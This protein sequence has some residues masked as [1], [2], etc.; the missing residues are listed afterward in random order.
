MTGKGKKLFSALLLIAVLCLVCTCAFAAYNWVNDGGCG[1]DH[2]NPSGAAVGCD[3]HAYEYKQVDAMSHKKTQWH[4]PVKEGANIYPSFFTER[5]EWS[6]SGS[7]DTTTFTCKFCGYS[8]TTDNT[9]ISRVVNVVPTCVSTGSA[10]WSWVRHA[11][12]GTNSNYGMLET[13]PVD[14]NNHVG[15]TYNVDT[16]KPSCT[17]AHEWNICCSSCNAVIGQDHEHMVRSHGYG[18]N[19]EWRV[20]KPATCGASGVESRICTIKWDGVECGA[21]IETRSIPATGKHTYKLGDYDK[22]KANFTCTTCRGTWQTG[23]RNSKV[24]TDEPATCIGT[25]FTEYTFDIYD[26]DGKYVQE[27]AFVTRYAV[28]PKKHVGGTYNVQTVAPTC[29]TAEEWDVYCSSC[30]TVIRHDFERFARSHGSK[31][32][33]RT[34]KPASCTADGQKELVCTA[35][36]G[37]KECG[38][39]MQTE[40]IPATGHKWDFVSCSKNNSTWKCLTCGQQTTVKNKNINKKETPATCTKGGSIVYYADIIDP[41]G[42][43]YRSQ[44]GMPSQSIPAPGHSFG[45]WVTETEATC[46]Q[47]GKEIRTCGICGE[48]EERVISRKQHDFGESEV[49]KK[50]SCTEIGLEKQTCKICGFELETAGKYAPGHKYGQE[51]ERVDPTADAAGYVIYRCTNVWYGVQCDATCRVDLAKLDPQKTGE[52]TADPAGTPTAKPTATPTAKPTAAPTAKPT[53]TPTAKP[54]AAPT[55]KPTAT[56]TAKPTTAPTAEPEGSGGTPT[57]D[58]EGSGGTPTADPEGSGETP[59]T[60]PEGS[61]ET[62][63]TDP[64]GSGGTPTADPEGSGETP[65]ADPEG[66]GGTPTAKPDETDTGKHDEEPEGGTAD[67][68]TC[69]HEHTTVF[70]GIDPTC[71]ADGCTDT[72]VCDDCGKVISGGEII[73]AKGHTPKDVDRV[74]PTETKDGHEAGQVCEDCGK[75]LE[76]CEV[77]PKTGSDSGDSETPGGSEGTEDCPH[78]KLRYQAGVEPTCTE[79]GRSSGVVCEDCGKLIAGGETIP[80]LGHDW[81]HVD[82]EDPTATESGHE[83]GTRCERCGETEGCEEIPALGSGADPETCKHE[84]TH[85]IPGQEPTCDKPGWEDI[86]VCEDCGKTLSGCGEIPALGHDPVEVGRVEPTETEPGHEEGHV[87][88]R[89]GEILDG[90]K[91]IP[92]T[93]KGNTDLLTK[94]ADPDDDVEVRKIEGLPGHVIVITGGDEQSAAVFELVE[95]H[96]GDKCPWC[97]DE[98]SEW[99]DLGDGRHIRVCMDPECLYYE[100]AEHPCFIICVDG[101]DYSICPICGAFSGDGS[102]SRLS[103]VNS[104]DS[105]ALYAFKDIAPWGESAV[106]IKNFSDDKVT[107]AG[108]FTVVR[109]KDGD[110]ALFGGAVDLLVPVDVNASQLVRMTIEGEFTDV[111]AAFLNGHVLFGTDDNGLYLL[112][113]K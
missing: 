17:K 52:P 12:D 58:P 13:L 103:G 22:N 112:L 40:K 26:P 56:P 28:D 36:W 61:G 34:V 23:N 76:G 29:T 65:T 74:E 92:A 59:T 70:P 68:E 83:A 89:C 43:V 82:R 38:Y 63:T 106:I 45:D 101:V 79:P 100:V 44:Y 85:M 53:A 97:G 90:C 105:R 6:I 48:K 41:D 24:K 81:K 67:P 16:V 20:T 11:P 9:D 64:E 96:D 72:V 30:N 111:T 50:K 113:S 94:D 62:P 87:C 14:P 31:S 19:S 107:V 109:E 49:V 21:V 93:G 98:M 15:G 47:N 32:E 95:G 88:G 108:A 4:H 99:I 33:W 77:L 110:L 71:E 27:G 66:S 69:R 10:T 37:G 2:K 75:I 46:T 35:E 80:A 7:K 25:G 60:D 91:E 73:P 39:V 18:G 54:T 104:S 5:H 1:P 86:T 51:I 3:N 55:A 8:E 84:H 42:N 57:A 78:E 102:F